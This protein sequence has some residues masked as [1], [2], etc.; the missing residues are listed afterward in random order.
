MSGCLCAPAR[1]ALGEL[2]RTGTTFL[3]NGYF[4][5]AE[6]LASPRFPALFWRCSSHQCCKPIK[7]PGKLRH[8]AVLCSAAGRD[9]DWERAAAP[10]SPTSPGH[11][12]GMWM[13]GSSCPEQPQSRPIYRVHK[14]PVPT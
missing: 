2:E 13:G 4:V 6:Y 12:G 5:Q 11:T 7:H 3:V 1:E 8:G 14:A 10:G 9:R